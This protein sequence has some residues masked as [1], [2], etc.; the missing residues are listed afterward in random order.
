MK[1]PEASCGESCRIAFAGDAHTF[2]EILIKPCALE[3]ATCVLEEQSTKELEIIQLSSNNVR[4]LI[5]ELSADIEKQLVS[6]L[7]F[8][9]AFFSAT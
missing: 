9:V 6:L 7:H 3:L 4:L 8:T 5:Q 1:R 2:A